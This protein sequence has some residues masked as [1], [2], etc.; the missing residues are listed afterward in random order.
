MGARRLF[1]A[2][3]AATA[4]GLALA[5]PAQASFHEMSIR[6]VYPGGADEASYVELQMWAAGQEFVSGHHLVAYNANGSVAED[7][8]FA[9]NVSGGANQST[10][11]VADSGYGGVF[12]GRPAP[13]ASDANLDLSPAGGAV[14][15]VEGSPPDCVAW[16]NFTGPL[17]A[18]APA[19]VV[20]S[21]A[22]PA[23]VPAGMALRRTIAPGCSTL[24]ELGDDSNDS[25][26]DFSPVAPDPRPNSVAPVE[27]GCGSGGGG[28]GGGTEGGSGGG[29]GGSGGQGH[30]SPQTILS[31]KPPRTTHDRTPS[32]RFR[33]DEN[34]ASFQCRV[35]R[36]RFKPCRSPFTAK[37]LGLGRHTFAVRARE[38][39]GGLDPSPASC[40]F[41][42]V[43]RG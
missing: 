36:G 14:C 24:L 23:G 19:L 33:S 17:P 34:G 10:V 32:F 18:H 11:L 37:R 39:S 30:G 31:A 16:G 26:T 13:D 20:G 4:I 7:F 25:A 5:A 40:A 15:W 9:A 38:A 35:D 1:A 28:G 42:V 2:T 21:P 3:L 43:R 29:G 27:H 12:A 22:A 41:R 8:K 6:E